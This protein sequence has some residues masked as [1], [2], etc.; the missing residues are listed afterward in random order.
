MIQLRAPV[1]L[2]GAELQTANVASLLGTPNRSPTR[3]SLLESLHSPSAAERKTFP[4]GVQQTWHSSI[5]D[6]IG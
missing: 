1:Y 2:F 6:A 5:Y 3:W 4:L